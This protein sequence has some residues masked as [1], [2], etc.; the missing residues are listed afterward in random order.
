MSSIAS[1][2]YVDFRCFAPTAPSAV[3]CTFCLQCP[4]SGLVEIVGFGNVIDDIA[5]LLGAPLHCRAVGFGGV[6]FRGGHVALDDAVFVAG[7]DVEFNTRAGVADIYFLIA[8]AHSS[9]DS[10][11]KIVVILELSVI[12]SKWITSPS[13]D[14]R[15]MTFDDPSALALA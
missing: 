13:S 12:V 8:V 15:P 6:D 10:F 11:R 5:I 2:I 7:V 1:R 9:L 14:P 4:Y 3:E